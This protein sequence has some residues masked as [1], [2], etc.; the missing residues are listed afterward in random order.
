METCLEPEIINGGY[1]SLAMVPKVELRGLQ[2][3]IDEFKSYLKTIKS[4]GAGNHETEERTI[5]EETVENLDVRAKGCRQP[6]M[7]KRTE[8]V[9]A[10]E[11]AGSEAAGSACSISAL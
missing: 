8:A 7:A 4:H 6:Y 11:A 3:A 9:E 2:C 1:S 5:K 10:D